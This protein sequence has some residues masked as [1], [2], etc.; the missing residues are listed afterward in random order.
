MRSISRRIFIAGGSTA[1]AF[2]LFQSRRLLGAPLNLP[3]GL[4]LYSVRQALAQD[5]TG[6]LQQVANIGY[7]EVEAAGFYGHSAADVK[8]LMANAGLNCVSAHYSLADL[9]KAEDATID[10]AKTLGLQYIICSAPY[11]ADPSRFAHG[12]WQGMQHGLPL[13]DWKWNTDQFNRLGKK[14]KATGLQFGYHN[15]TMEFLDLGDGMTGFEAL[16]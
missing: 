6:T 16:L 15:H 11:V 12:A 9:L 5:Y 13:D 4:Q 10:Y 3:A 1:A 8:Q 14:L 2:A 7:R